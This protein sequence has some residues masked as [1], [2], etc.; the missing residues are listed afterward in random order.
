MTGNI[1]MLIDDDKTFN[2]LTSM[3]IKRHIADA[4]LQIYASAFSAL[5]YI[6]ANIG[7]VSALPVFIFL[8]IRMPQIDGFEFLEQLNSFDQKYIQNIRIA[9]LT[10]SL[11]NDDHEKAFSYK[12][13]KYFLEKPLIVQKLKELDLGLDLC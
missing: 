4:N 7:N 5:E 3:V 9:I 11:Y 6:E 2:M 8:D 12:Q 13:V 10:S 1:I